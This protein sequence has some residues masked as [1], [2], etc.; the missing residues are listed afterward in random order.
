MGGRHLHLFASCSDLAGE[1]AVPSFEGGDDNQLISP[2][3]CRHLLIPASLT[4]SNETRQATRNFIVQVSRL[5]LTI[6]TI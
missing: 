5:A 1:G 2:R 3:Q 6:R 4:A